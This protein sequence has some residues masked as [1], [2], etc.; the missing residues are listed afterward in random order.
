[1][2][3]WHRQVAVQQSRHRGRTSAPAP[4]LPLS[5]SYSLTAMKHQAAGCVKDDASI[6]LSW[7]ALCLWCRV[8]GR[9]PRVCSLGWSGT[10][11]SRKCRVLELVLL[12]SETENKGVCVCARC[13]AEH[14]H[15]GLSGTTRP[16][17]NEPPQ[18]P[19]PSSRHPACSAGRLL[20]S[21]GRLQH[22]E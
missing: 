13:P 6:A 18:H 16:S 11:S 14:T 12:L 19:A 3:T 21:V 10:G 1:M 5:L 2:A 7:S 8:S 22:S 17:T 20:S 15:G 4:V 9:L